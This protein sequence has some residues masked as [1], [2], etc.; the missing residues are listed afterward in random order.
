MKII[1]KISLCFVLDEEGHRKILKRRG[2]LTTKGAEKQ[3]QEIDRI[4]NIH[5]KMVVMA[6]ENEWFQISISLCPLFLSLSI[7]I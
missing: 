1:I 6:M 2:E 5:D 4:R 7:H 3:L